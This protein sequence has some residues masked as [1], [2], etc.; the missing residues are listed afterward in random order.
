MLKIENLS[1]NYGYITALKNVSLEVKQGEIITLIGGNGAGK[2]TTLMSISGLVE[3]ARGKITFKGEDITRKA[4][5]KIVKMGLSHVPEGR[6]IFPA[7]TVYENLITGTL[8]N[9]SLKKDKI[10]ELIEMNYTL[11]P[12]L[13]ER[14]TQGGGS[15]SGG[16]QQMLAIA[17]GLMMDPDIIMLDEPSLGLAPIIVEEIFELVLKIRDKGKTVLLIEQNASMALSIADRGYVLETGDVI[18]EGKGK[19]LLNDPEVKRA[20]LGA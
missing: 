14:T 19:N 18:L 6:R 5:D 7:L 9:P 3:K 16:E 11:F 8:G 15:L 17:R 13:K 20:Y 12:R 4:P 2:T 1:V 10:E